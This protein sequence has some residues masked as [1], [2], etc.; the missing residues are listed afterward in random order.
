VRAVDH[1]RFGRTVAFVS[2]PDGRDLGRELVGAGAA[3]HYARYSQDAELGKLEAQARAARAGLSA[4]PLPE[5]PV[6]Y[7]AAR[8][9]R[10]AQRRQ[11][12]R[13]S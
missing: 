12:R 13:S 7:R 2:L 9:G 6:F 5:P 1:D 4:E 3:W 11:Q 8:R 10:S